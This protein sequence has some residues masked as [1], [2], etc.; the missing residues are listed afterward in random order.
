MKGLTDACAVA[1][2]GLRNSVAIDLVVAQKP[3]PGHSAVVKPPEHLR[4]QRDH[5]P[6]PEPLIPRSPCLP[7]ALFQS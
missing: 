2:G 7:L 4:G 3:G 1:K 5:Q 6:S